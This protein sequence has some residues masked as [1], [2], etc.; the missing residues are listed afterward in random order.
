MISISFFTT[1]FKKAQ[2]Q[3]KNLG[4]YPTTYIISAATNALLLFPEVFSQRFK[5]SLITV[6]TNLFSSSIVIHPE[7]EPRAQ[8]SLFNLSKVKKDLSPVSLSSLV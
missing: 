6:T 4:N 1:V 8:Q 5:S 7:I 2:W 3:H